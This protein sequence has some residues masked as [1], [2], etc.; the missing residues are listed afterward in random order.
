MCGRFR[1]AIEG[2]NDYLAEV[3]DGPDARD[4]R[5][6]LT[7]FN[8]YEFN[9]RYI[10]SPLLEVPPLDLI[11]YSPRSATPLYDAVVKMIKDMEQYVSEVDE[12]RVVITILT[13]GLENAS[14]AYDGAEV[15]RLVN[16]KQDK[17]WAVTYLGTN[18]DA[19]AAAEGIGIGRG[20]SAG[21]EPTPEGM[22]L[23]FRSMAR[24]TR[25]YMQS[26]DD[27]P[28]QLLCASTNPRTGLLV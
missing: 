25:Q 15:S 28:V 17:G 20:N 12:P 6:S 4:V 21:F 18:Q 10:N 13:D 23:A 3:K 22:H 2:F 7:T 26:D 27:S 8:S 9:R 19:W 5:F 14:T 1:A 11:T 24:A 16:R